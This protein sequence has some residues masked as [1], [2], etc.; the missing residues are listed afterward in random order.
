MYAHNNLQMSHQSED[1]K[2][3]HFNSKNNYLSVSSS[4]ILKD[5]F[6]FFPIFNTFIYLVP[7]LTFLLGIILPIKQLLQ[8]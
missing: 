7:Y 6:S 2:K 5:F 3:Y 8:S 1:I 4:F